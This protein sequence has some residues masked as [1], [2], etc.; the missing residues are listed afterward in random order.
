[1]FETHFDATIHTLIARG[2]AAVFPVK[3]ADLLPFVQGAALG[4]ALR[5]CEAR[6]IASDFQLTRAALLRSAV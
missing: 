6:W 5:K 3:S 4:Q 2:A 1:L